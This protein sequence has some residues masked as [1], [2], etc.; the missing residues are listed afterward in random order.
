[1]SAPPLFSIIVPTHKRP[2][3]LGRALQSI[4]QQSLMEHHTEASLEILVISDVLDPATDA[5]C[6]QLLGPHDAY[7]R[8][9]GAAGP[10]ASRNQGLEIAQG[11]YVLFLDDDDALQP[12]WLAKLAATSAFER[13]V[14]L[15]GDCTVIAERRPPT[16]PELL[17]A[18]PMSCAGLLNDWLH[19]KNQVHMSCYALPRSFIGARRFDCFMRAYEDWEFLLGLYRKQPAEHVAIQASFVFE[20]YDET[21]DRRGASLEASGTDA[22]LDYL[23]VYR[24]Y[25]APDDA[26]RQQRAA[27]L[28]A[29]GMHV[30]GQFL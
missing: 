30:S 4:K 20:V 13:Q 15:Y 5:V 28:A 3:L 19:V 14:P 21:S 11:R 8:R 12:D 22:V 1:M 6:S 16:G 25:P 27:L 24:R 26:M 9:N 10:S 2:V 23:Y 17:G 7:L 29:H 18:S